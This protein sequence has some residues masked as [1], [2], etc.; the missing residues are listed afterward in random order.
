MKLLVQRVS[1]ARVEVEGQIVGEIGAGLM[2]LAGCRK[3]DSES[4][5][6]YLADKLIA[7][8]IFNDEQGRMNLDVRDT[9]GG[10]LIVSQFTLYADTRKGNRPGF[11]LSGDPA[12]AEKLCTRLVE[13]VTD[14]LG[15]EKVSTGRFAA[16]MQVTL[17][18][19][20]PVT[21]ELC[22]DT[23]FP[24]GTDGRKQ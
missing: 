18:N 1:H 20:G 6:N 19:D 14:N 4:D 22:S 8:R 13:R 7:L 12:I 11:E 21:I 24:K 16:E 3:G 17:C 9:G 10:V 15:T 2:V 23:R 5:V